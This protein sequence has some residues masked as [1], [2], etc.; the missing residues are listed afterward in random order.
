MNIC[1]FFFLFSMLVKDKADTKLRNYWYC[2]SLK[3]CCLFML[4]VF[5]THIYARLVEK[6]TGAFL[7]T[8]RTKLTLIKFG[9]FVVLIWS[10][11]HCNAHCKFKW[12]LVWYLNGFHIPYIFCR[13]FMVFFS[14]INS[15]TIIKM[16]MHFFLI[17]IKEKT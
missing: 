16:I 15:K 4:F 11:C 13:I 2:Y 5:K 14:L 12:L 17:E 10:I 7:W 1:W 8:Q 9:I 6:K 3:M